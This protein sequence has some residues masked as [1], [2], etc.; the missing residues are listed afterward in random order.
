MPGPIKNRLEKRISSLERTEN[1]PALMQLSS[2]IRDMKE[3]KTKLSVDE[4]EGLMVLYAKSGKEL[5]DRFK[6]IRKQNKDQVSIETCKKLIK[7][8]SK[9]YTALFRY[10]KH[11]KKN[12][13]IM[14]VGIE[15]FFEKYRTR[16]I[17]LN[18]QALDEQKSVSAHQNV[19]YK[20]PLP[21]QDE[22]G[23]DLQK[24][25]IVSAYFTEN[26][27]FLKL[28]NQVTFNDVM[29][30][31]EREIADN[32]GKKYPYLTP[33]I[34][35]LEKNHG[36]L[37]DFFLY[38]IPKDLKTEYR[39][40]GDMTLI[41]KGTDGF[42]NQMIDFAKQQNDPAL[43]ILQDIKKRPKAERDAIVYGLSEYA[44]GLWTA[45]YTIHMK[46]LAEMNQVTATG[47]RNAL[48]SVVADLFE[49]GDVVAHSEKLNVKS[50]EN[51]KEVLKKGV[52]MM[53]AAGEDG[54]YSGLY[55]NMALFDRSQM[56]N[57]PSLTKS[58]AELQL[59]DYICGNVDRHIGNLFFQ[60]KNGKM[61]GVQ[62]IDNDTAFGSLL[63]PGK[64]GNGIAFKDLRIISKPMADAIMTVNTDTFGMILEGYGLNG[65][66]I[67]TAMK[68][69]DDVKEKLN[70]STEYYKNRTVGY[71]DPE[72][73][74]IVPVN[75]MN[76]YSV[77]EQLITK[78]NGKNE[79]IFGKII[80]GSSKTNSLL[81]QALSCCNK[82]ME[83]SVAYRK[84]FYDN[85]KGSLRWN[86]AEMDKLL[87]ASKEP[88]ELFQKMRDASALIVNDEK[89]EL[90]KDLV[91]T[92]SNYV[93]ASNTAGINLVAFCGKDVM[94]KKLD[95]ALEL[96]Y[97]YLSSEEAV[98][99][100][101][102]YQQLQYDLKECSPKDV[103]V[104][105]NILKEIDELKESDGFKKYQA[106]L[107]NR[108][109]LSEQ[110]ERY[111]M[112]NE[113][114]GE[115]TKVPKRLAQIDKKKLYDPYAGSKE[116]AAAKQRKEK[117]RQ[118]TEEMN[119]KA[120]KKKNMVKI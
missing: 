82:M 119:A 14:P 7:N 37:Y 13:N 6:K 106:A 43:P 83:T 80:N 98:E 50:F 101:D 18:G 89:G 97:E 10:R 30:E 25:D 86:T 51:G 38:K 91:R 44:N 46:M 71:L 40:D 26:R 41:K 39:I 110:L 67:D 35:P 23:T 9:D 33:V 54:D 64:V 103:A 56:E 31:N 61:T 55:S 22:P 3:K 68:R 115:L 48:M 96:T 105:K 99:T 2:K 113:I 107:T 11:L 32:V 120:N 69:L 17:S 85:S 52:V 12:E 36:R 104:R 21:I 60:F 111:T 70:Y 84:A 5:I 4:I 49:C 16:T 100:A 88:D 116:E 72:V 62:G 8:M 109:R 58:I 15:E 20:V 65:K 79:N 77:N 19:R 93:K 63:D 53:P 73:P 66:E 78:N 117:A 75:E 76:Q 92:T 102:K 90:H 29:L 27:D 47:K 81:D 57:S 59:L 74:R 34:T 42:L 94:R 1:M 28:G 95:D 87:I 112:T 24:G 114:C 45:E 108:D 118:K